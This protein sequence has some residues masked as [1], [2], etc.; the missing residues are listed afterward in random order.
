MPSIAFAVV[1]LGALLPACGRKTIPKAPE[2]VRPKTIDTLEVLQAETG[3]KLS[4]RRPDE[5][6][7]GSNMPD[8]GTF[9]VE[10]AEGDG[11]FHAIQTLP[12]TDHERFQKIRRLHYTDSTVSAGTRYRYRVLSST[13]DDYVSEPSNVVEFVLP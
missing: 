8:L 10:R 12:V 3:A 11:P 5:Y 1:V 7:D 4:W 9:T 13:L 6:A 2:L